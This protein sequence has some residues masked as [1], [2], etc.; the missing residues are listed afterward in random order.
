[1]SGSGLYHRQPF[2]K[3]TASLHSPECNHSIEM[4]Q[5]K[6]VFKQHSH[7]DQYLSN[8][9]Q[10]PSHRDD[11]PLHLDLAPLRSA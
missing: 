1:M 10:R 7:R 6:P 9:L 11:F 8:F 3:V 4:F 5:L 2:L